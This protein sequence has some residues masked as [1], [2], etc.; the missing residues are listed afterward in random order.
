MPESAPAT[1]R[2]KLRKAL[3]A[4]DRPLGWERRAGLHDTV[5][6]GGL[7]AYGVRW[8]GQAVDACTDERLAGRLAELAPL[9]AR[10]T[11]AEPEERGALLDAIEQRLRE[12]LQSLEASSAD[13]RAT[14]RER[15]R[16]LDAREARDLRG[17]RETPVQFVRGVGPRLA[18]LLARFGIST[19]YDLLY[20]FP[21]AHQDRRHPT[22]VRELVDD[23]ATGV[24]VRLGA[25]PKEQRMRRV[26]LVTAM[27]Y[28][29]SGMVELAWYNQPWLVGK[30]ARG[31]RIYAVGKS[32][33]WGNRPRMVVQEYEVIGTEQA[34][35]QIGRI[36]P[37]YPLT[38]GLS[39]GRIRSVLAQAVEHY[40]HG[41]YDPVPSAIREHRGLLSLAQ[42]IRTIHFP[43]DPE[44]H[45]LARIRLAF[46]ELLALQV[47]VAQRRR[48]IS[49]GIALPVRPPGDPIAELEGALPF[50]FTAAQRRASK[51]ILRDLASS[52]P[53]NR[54][55]H[56]DV[57]SGKTAVVMAA[58][59]AVARAG[60]QSALMVPTEILA[61]QHFA[62][63]RRVLE[64]LGV[65]VTMLVGSLPK[66]VRDE[67]RERVRMADA[68]VVVGTHAL[69]QEGVD[70]A[71]LGLAVVD[72]QHRFGV[73][74]RS[75]LFTKATCPHFLVLTATPI[76]RTLALTVYGHLAVSQLDEMPPGRQE[77]VTKTAGRKAAYALVRKETAKG[78]QAYVICPL[79]E[80]S[81]VLDCEAAADLAQRLAEED[82]AGL[83]IGLLHGRLP[84]EEREA[85]MGAFARGEIQVLV[86]T[87]V[88]EVG[89][90]V[91]NATVIVIENA[92]RFGLAQ[93]HQLR[94]RVGRGSERSYCALICGTRSQEARYRLEVLCR[95]TD[96]FEIAMEDLRLRGPG[97]FFGTRQ[98]GLPDLRVADVLSDV[99]ILEMA[100]VDAEAL[101][102]ED[103]ELAA[104]RHADLREDILHGA[105]TKVTRALM[106]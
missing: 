78:R 42:A 58:L 15:D 8:L 17:A 50:A 86:S 13:W 81:E 53:M 39:Q 32:E 99:E 88:V 85:T 49:I 36:V 9:L 95:T 61:Q 25:E 43:A 16:A 56:G 18:E 12:A 69:I 20:L 2:E 101:V 45:E 52:T 7:S 84:A 27:A 44:E 62:N 94:G 90:D 76:P 37:V 4:L 80:R 74:Q 100:R 55:L 10:Y 102:A 79:I 29:D 30:L 38:E 91:P 41:D 97:E 103:P 34:P 60:M 1:R 72:E 98:S 47:Q 54:L 64:P 24:L 3:E 51:R 46:G 83:T 35:T 28:D 22:P 71:R 92:E 57:G 5:A 75:E 23:V 65:G 87:T 96:G 40:A 93:L 66:R 104:P 19:A 26:T 21:R 6:S 77:I 70:F 59:L 33:R 73:A 89:V 63:L 11:P 31:D 48:E 106:G 105:G 68:S 67:R 14:A 82:L